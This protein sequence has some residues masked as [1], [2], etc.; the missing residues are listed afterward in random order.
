MNRTNAITD[1]NIKCIPENGIAALP[2]KEINAGNWTVLVVPYYG[3]LLPSRHNA[4]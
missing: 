1:L 4:L 2:Y 3:L